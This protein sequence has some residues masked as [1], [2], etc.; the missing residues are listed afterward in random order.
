ML[1]DGDWVAAE[2]GATFQAVSPSSGEVIGTVPSGSREDVRRAVAAAGRALEGWAALSA[3]DRAA[4]MRRVA[5]VIDERRDD[6][7]RT[8]SLDQ[9]KPLEAEARDEVEELLAYFEMAA[10][11]AVRMDGVIP[12]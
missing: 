9:G 3:F 4:A 12:P 1:I 11:D 2:D 6:L 7:A 10:A 8:L 5:S